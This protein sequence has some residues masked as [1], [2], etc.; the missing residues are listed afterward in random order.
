MYSVFFSKID[1]SFKF[2][3]NRLK[4]IIKI[5]DKVVVIPWSFPIE[6]N[7]EGVDNFF[8]GN[9]RK[10]YISPLLKLGIDE[11]NITVLNCYRD[12][13][14]YMIKKI[15]DSNI[16]VLPGGNPEMLYN[17]IKEKGLSMYI[18]NYKKII[19]GESAGTEL[20]LN[21]YFITAKNN[22]YKKFDWYKGFNVIDDPFYMDVHTSNNYN[23]IKKLQKTA[24]EKNKTV[25][26][27]YDDGVI[28]LNRNT[29]KE[30][31]YGNV[32][33]IN[34][35]KSKLI[36]PDYKNSI[37]NLA[38]S[39]KKY[40][41]LE[42]NHNTI[43]DIDDLLNQKKYKNIVVILF[44]GM[45]SEIIKNNLRKNSFLI[46]NMKK[47]IF[48]VVPSTTT[49]ATTSILSGLTPKEH[50]WLG[51]DMYIK[52]EDKIVTMFKNKIKDT[53]IEAAYYNVAKKY[54]SYKTII[55]S[56]N[57]NPKYYSSLLSPYENDKYNDINDMLKKIRK[58][59]NK[60]EKNYIYAYYDIPDTIMH[61]EGTNSKEIKENLKLI[62][63]KVKEFSKTLKDTLLIITA[64]HG[65]KNCNEI[66]LEEYPDLFD[67]LDGNVWLEGRMCTFKIKHNREKEFVKLFKKYF[68]KD[69]ILKTKK[70]IIDKNIFGIGTEN[71]Y[72]VD[73]LGD[74]F[75]LGVGNKYFRYK[76]TDKV[77][78]STHAGFTIDEMKVPLIIVD[79][80]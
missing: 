58:S 63:N 33:I 9:K 78:K 39:I 51:W 47:E 41:D 31:L 28:L 79:K 15:N 48:S 26:A 36:L 73:S 64:D 18:K 54:F 10:K 75:A 32:K 22:Y 38:C 7:A 2:I 72:F 14:D 52:S 8:S 71:K 1:I 5:R 6:T 46:K 29:N 62:N 40:F 27:I 69:F 43:K 20:Q 77:K 37:V 23:Y 17:K 42:Y 12:K 11:K 4:E 66:V 49:A 25:Y 55:E 53:D 56:I 50:G 3:E 67:T 34:P 65:H 13:T 57:E 19:I 80:K 44:D 70:Q 74:Y 61:K 60:K 68:D 24:N 76:K 21:N 59:L 35:E 30:E 16:L 45:G